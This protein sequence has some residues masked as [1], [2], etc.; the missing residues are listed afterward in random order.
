VSNDKKVK[1]AGEELAFAG[2]TGMGFSPGM[3]KREFFAIEILA[4]L[5]SK[6]GIQDSEEQVD[7]AIKQTDKLIKQLNQNTEES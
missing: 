1:K 6:Y 3:T 5:A 4:A 2:R 7:I